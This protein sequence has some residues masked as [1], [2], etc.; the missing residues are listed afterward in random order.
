MLVKIRMK[1]NNIINQNHILTN[2]INISYLNIEM[3]TVQLQTRTLI[4]K[5]GLLFPVDGP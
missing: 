3:A 5:G 2:K 4:F 1:K